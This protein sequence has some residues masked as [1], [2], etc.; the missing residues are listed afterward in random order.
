MS[1]KNPQPEYRL[2]DEVRSR[3]VAGVDIVALEKLLGA[4]PADMRQPIL[5]TFTKRHRRDTS[6]SQTLG[7]DRQSNYREVQGVH[8]HL[9][10]R[11]SDLSFSDHRLQSLLEDVLPASVLPN[12]EDEQAARA[13]RLL[14]HEEVGVVLVEALPD[15]A[16]AAI[17]RR[18]RE[19]PR[20]FVLISSTYADVYQLDLALRTLIEARRATPSLVTG[21][22]VKYMTEAA[23]RLKLPAEWAQRLSA[24]LRFAEDA[25]VSEVPIAGLGKMVTFRFV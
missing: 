18:E 16:I 1:D 23:P 6:A 20:D 5:D 9:P 19:R 13:E 8:V 11:A 21:G 7:Q 24:V 25:T 10:A 17:Y 4:V 14:Y 15:A 12:E 22:V 3:L 2:S